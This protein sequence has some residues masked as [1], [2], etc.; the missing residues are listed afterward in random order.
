MNTSDHRLDCLK[1]SFI[2]TINTPN[3]SSQ[4]AP[5]AEPALGLRMQQSKL[6]ALDTDSIL[7]HGENEESD[8]VM[9]EWDATLRQG[10]PWTHVQD[11]VDGIPTA[12][13]SCRLIP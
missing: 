11:V 5:E 12:V 7:F 10:T 4:A 13:R 8:A 1:F 9:V 2:L 6:A 3:L